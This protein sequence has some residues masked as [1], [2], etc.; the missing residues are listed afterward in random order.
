MKITKRFNNGI[1]G[2]VHNVKLFVIKKEEKDFSNLPDYKLVIID[3]NNTVITK[4]FYYYRDNNM[5][6]DLYIKD[7]S[8]LFKSM[9]GELIIYSKIKSLDNLLDTTMQIINKQKEN[10]NFNVFVTYGTTTAPSKYLKLRFS[11]YIEPSNIDLKKSK[12]IL[13]SNDLLINENLT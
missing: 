3:S 11:N 4:G 12:L 1:A 7:I 2:K 10:N 6:K 9:T 8:Y 5:N 13:Q